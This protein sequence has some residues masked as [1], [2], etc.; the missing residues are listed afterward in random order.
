MCVQMLY[1]DMILVT[2][3]SL[4]DQKVHAL[5][6]AVRVPGRSPLPAAHA[7]EDVVAVQDRVVLEETC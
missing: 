4:H 3:K 2:L 5:P 6:G 7:R 1:V